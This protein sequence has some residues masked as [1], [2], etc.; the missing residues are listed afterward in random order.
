MASPHAL[1]SALAD[2]DRLRLFARICLAPEGLPADTA[3]RAAVRRLVT[4]GL[5]TEDGGHLHAVP[6]AFRD[7]LA[8]PRST[9]PVDALFRDGR[10]VAIPRPGPRRR[11]LLT[12]LADR[13]E[14]GRVYTEREVRAT[15]TAVHDDH[16]LLRRALVDEGLLERSADGRS[17][18]RP[19]GGRVQ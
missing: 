16:A 8:T 19:A 17:Y 5:V 15:L 2:P 3:P 13:F 9:D 14:P 18:G 10:L 1:V 4:A 11:A 12:R 6:A 7:A